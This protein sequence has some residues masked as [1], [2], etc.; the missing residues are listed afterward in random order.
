[1]EMCTETQRT[2][3]RGKWIRETAAREM[4]PRLVRMGKRTSKDKSM[5]TVYN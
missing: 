3:L 2:I 5:K 1:M 4:I